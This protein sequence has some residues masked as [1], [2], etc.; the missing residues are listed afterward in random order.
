MPVSRI[1]KSR[2]SGICCALPDNSVTVEEYGRD[3]FSPG[4]ILKAS[5]MIGTKNL[6]LAR[7]GQTAADLCYGAA[8]KIINALHWQ[9]EEIDGLLFFSQTPDHILP[10]TSFFLQERLGLSRNCLALD[11][12]LGC[13]SFVYGLWLAGQLIAG[14]TCRK[15]LLLIGDTLSKVL[16]REDR[17]VSLVFGDGAS[18]TALEY[19]EKASPGTAVLYSDGALARDIIIP[20]G[21]GRYP[22]D[23]QS[24]T[25]YT[26]EQGNA[27]SAENLYM[28]GM[29]VFL[30]S[31]RE[32]PLLLER[33]LALHGWEKNEV[34][35]FLLHQANQYILQYIMQK[36]GIP[37]E[38][39]P[40]NIGNYGNTSGATLPLLIC[41]SLRHVLAHGS[42]RVILAGFGAGFSWGGMAVELSRVHCA[43][44]IY[45]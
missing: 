22:A 3:Y 6:Y 1:S 29:S 25:M 44:I 45:L 31:I 39:V 43:E 4:E 28:N 24:K 33:V 15:V 23:E 26:D 36:S 16:S 11:I 42:A 19:D 27:R 2:I 21:G 41:D 32:V 9:R 35:Y 18:A 17:S 7:P 37:P 20:A 10:A 12:N 40:L 14:G 13:S 38:K 5:G 34:D 8:E 30:F